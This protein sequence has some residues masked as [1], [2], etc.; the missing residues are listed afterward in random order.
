MIDWENFHGVLRLAHIVGGA[1]GLVMFWV[2]VFTK[3][4]SRTHVFSG[5]AFVW[6]AYVVS[7]TAAV[8]SV[9]ALT[10][11]IHFTG[12]ARSLT[13]SETQLVAGNVRFLFAILGTLMLW[14]VAAVQLGVY[15]MRNKGKSTD[16]RPRVMAFQIL[17]GVASLGLVVFGVANHFAVGESRYI[18]PAVLGAFGVSEH[19]KTALFL[20]RPVQG[21]AWWTMHMECMLGAG[22]AFHTAFFVFGANRLFGISLQGPLAIIPWILPSLIGVPATTIWIRRYKKAKEPYVAPATSTVG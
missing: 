17:A 8:S 11:P 19:R 20:S 22:I 15:S 10:A 21:N 7:A 18:L 4:G 14:L 13:E 16:G 3:K 1:V 6:L 2:P 12:I 9:W 5:K